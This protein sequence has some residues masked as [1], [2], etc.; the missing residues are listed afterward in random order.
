MLLNISLD[1]FSKISNDIDQFDIHGAGQ[2]GERVD[3]V[4]EHSFTGYTDQLFRFAP[5]MWAKAGP[6]S[7]HWDNYFQCAI[8]H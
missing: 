3:D 4:I 2:R 7:G 8:C 1:L 6:Q 5:G